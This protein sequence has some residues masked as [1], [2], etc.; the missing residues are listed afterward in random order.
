MILI[1]VVAVMIN[2][3]TIGEKIFK[4]NPRAE[5]KLS[6][7]RAADADDLKSDIEVQCMRLDLH[8]Y[9]EIVPP[10][11]VQTDTYDKLCFFQG[12]VAATSH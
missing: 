8:I 7:A 4:N 9:E 3:R 11:T 1:A 6:P 5:S 2:K 12:S 10:N